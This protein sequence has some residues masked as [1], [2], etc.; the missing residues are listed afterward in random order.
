MPDSK[1][2]RREEQGT[3]S[4]DEAEFERN[5]RTSRWT[6][7][8]DEDKGLHHLLPLKEQG[9]LIQQDPLQLELPG[10]CCI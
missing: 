5:P 3:P 10:M 9:R 2:A 8:D 7:E 6:A 4:S 1:R